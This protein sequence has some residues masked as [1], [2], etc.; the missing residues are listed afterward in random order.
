MRKGQGL[1]HAC[2]AIR[3]YGH[4]KCS[5]S[6][7]HSVHPHDMRMPT[8]IWQS[9]DIE[10]GAVGVNLWAVPSSVS[11]GGP[12]PTGENGTRPILPVGVYQR[13]NAKGQCGEENFYDTG[14]R[15]S[16]QGGASPLTLKNI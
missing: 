16:Y 12:L 5:P 10:G 1:A 9:D 14:W 7:R 11:H 8:G 13:R 6:I 3:N 15:G 4:L 2:T